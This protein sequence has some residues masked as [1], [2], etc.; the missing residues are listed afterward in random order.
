MTYG[1]P[2]K[3]RMNVSAARGTSDLEEFGINDNYTKRI[4]TDDVT[5]PFDTATVWWIENG[6][7]SASNP[8]NYVT[9]RVARSLNSTSIAIREVNT[10]V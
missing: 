10:I 1:T 2:V 7:P 4:A 5:T 3:A 9:V 6:E 8:Y